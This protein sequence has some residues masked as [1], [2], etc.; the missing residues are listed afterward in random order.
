[1]ARRNSQAW[2]KVSAEMS[3]LRPGLAAVRE[4]AR[5][6]QGVREAGEL[7]DRICASVAETFG[8]GRA[9]ISRFRPETDK[10]ELLATH[11]I[12]AEAVRDRKSTRLNSSHQIITLS[13]HDALPI[14][15]E[16]RPGLAAVRE[17]ARSAQ[18]VREAGEL[19]DR[20]CASVAETF[21]F[22]RAGISRFRPETD[23][24]ELLAT[25]GISAEA[26]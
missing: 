1:M 10:L 25:H 2:S 3:E 14:L 9:G 23:K 4:L 20:I 16:L 7:L 18:G 12:S 15:S 17:L 5:S 21:G 26:V 22:G 19:L 8:F 11:G 13:L 24:L 6:A